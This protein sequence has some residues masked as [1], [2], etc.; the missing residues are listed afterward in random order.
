MPTA[1]PPSA[2]PPSSSPSPHLLMAAGWGARSCSGSAP[3][4]P[5][6]SARPTKPVVRWV[7]APAQPTVVANL[8]LRLTVDSRF[9]A[10]CV[11][12]TMDSCCCSA[13]EPDTMDERL[14]HS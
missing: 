6:S 2:S 1:L 4:P 9:Y 12:D 10:T 13:L 8:H 5:S 11:P 14:L 3:P 7:G